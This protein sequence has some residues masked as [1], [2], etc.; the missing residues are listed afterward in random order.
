MF[1]AGLEQNFSF[2]QV[3]PLT[4]SDVI[5]MNAGCSSPFLGEGAAG[6]GF[7]ALFTMPEKTFF[8]FVL[9]I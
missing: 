5:G 8:G 7:L 4:A 1:S 9:S 2:A 6:F 3:G